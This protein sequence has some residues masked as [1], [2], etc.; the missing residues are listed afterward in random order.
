ML[1][2]NST[3]GLNDVMKRRT[4][5]SQQPRLPNKVAVITGGN[6]GIGLATAEL[7]SREGARVVIFGRDPG[8]LQSAAARIGADTL[9][10]QG[11]V[12]RIAGLDRLFETVARRHGQ[13]DV[14]VANAGIAKFAP[15]SSFSEGLTQVVS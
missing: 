8:S 7:F 1:V 15:M 9:T 6:S 10:V 13:V 3:D 12:R 5:M 14:L 2:N 11:D 4:P